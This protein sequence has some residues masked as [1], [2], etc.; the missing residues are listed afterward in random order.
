MAAS[1]AARRALLHA[2]ADLDDQL[3]LAASHKPEHVLLDRAQKS[4][5]LGYTDVAVD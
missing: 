2:V 1:P 3:L 5:S 4:R